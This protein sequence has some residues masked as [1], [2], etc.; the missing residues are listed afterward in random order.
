M[1]LIDSLE[2]FEKKR[3]ALNFHSF[4]GIHLGVEKRNEICPPKCNKM[5]YELK[6]SPAYPF[7]YWETSEIDLRL[8]PHV[9]PYQKV[10]EQLAVTPD[11]MVAFVGG[12][13]GIFLGY[14]AL[15]LV[16]LLEVFFKKLGTV[17]RK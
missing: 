13:I 14:S 1:R 6:R 4:S 2:K 10:E 17:I 3:E 11:M 7:A 16:D 9:I 8:D 12:T 15:S 5:I